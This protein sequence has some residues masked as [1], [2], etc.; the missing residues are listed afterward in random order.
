MNKIL[1]TLTAIMISTSAMATDLPSGKYAPL[2]PVNP[3]SFVSTPTFYAGPF[4]GAGFPDTLVGGLIGVN[5]TSFLAGEVAYTYVNPARGNGYRS[6][7]SFNALPNLNVTDRLKV[8]GVGGVGYA[9][10]N[11]VDRPTWTAGAG[12]RYALTNHVALDTRYTH[13]ENFGNRTYTDDRVTAGVL[14]GF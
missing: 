8:Y 4:G 6:E 1:A 9:W 5:V 11:T 3:Y 12:L 13:V 2:P 7:A 10:S 14:V